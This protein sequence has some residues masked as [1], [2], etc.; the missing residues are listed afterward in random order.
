MRNNSLKSRKTRVVREQGLGFPC[1]ANAFEFGL[2]RRVGMIF[3]PSLDLTFLGEVRSCGGSATDQTDLSLGPRCCMIR[4]AS[5]I[6]SFSSWWRSQRQYTFGEPSSYPKKAGSLQTEQW[7]IIPINWNS[8]VRF[9]LHARQT[10]RSSPVYPAAIDLARGK[11]ARRRRM[12]A[13]A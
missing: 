4:I 12:D 8:P 6:G 1:P 2:C 11:P 5:A 7:C 13:R 10:P 3:A 9:P